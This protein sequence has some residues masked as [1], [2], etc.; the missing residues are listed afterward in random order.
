MSF[1]LQL[2][3]P[4]YSA[5]ASRGGINAYQLWLAAMRCVSDWDQKQNKLQPE[6]IYLT[7]M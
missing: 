4:S 6:R 7:I 1:I 3:L 2:L 5:V